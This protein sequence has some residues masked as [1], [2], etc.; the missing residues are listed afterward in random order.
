MKAFK[1]NDI[2]DISEIGDILLD[3]IHLC[4]STCSRFVI[5]SHTPVLS[6]PFVSCHSAAIAAILLYLFIYLGFY[7]TFDTV[8][9]ISRRVVGRA[10]ETSTYSSSGICTVNCRLTASNYQLSHLRP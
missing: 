6:K 3:K 5:V 10:E 1:V 8:Q 7:V 9:V 2:W 4:L